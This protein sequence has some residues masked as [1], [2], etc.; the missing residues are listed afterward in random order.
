LLPENALELVSQYDLVLEGA[1]N[2]ATKFLCADACRL[3]KV[4]VVHASAVRWYGLTVAVSREARPCYRCLFEDIP[5]G[6]AATCENA[7]VMAPVV[8]VVAALQ[9]D[10]A[11]RLL[12]G[13]P[14]GG[15]VVTFDG[16]TRAHRPFS[17]APRAAC[18]LCGDSPTIVAVERA[19]YAK[20]GACVGS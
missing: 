8:G 13:E 17:V 15:R 4:A 14:M 7:G 3:A 12:A 18:S 11:L 19:R 6:D 5:E 1:D 10:L 20:T 2:F 16:K 9:A